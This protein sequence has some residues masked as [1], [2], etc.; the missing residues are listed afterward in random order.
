MRAFSSVAM[1]SALNG[2]RFAF[3]MVSIRDVAVT[4]CDD[5]D[6]SDVYRYSSGSEEYDLGGV[7]SAIVRCCRGMPV[8][9]G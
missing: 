6:V 1:S 3:R 8:S 4:M 7:A 9:R 2:M 5:P